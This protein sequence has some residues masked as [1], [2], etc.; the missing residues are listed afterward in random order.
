MDTRVKVAHCESTGRKW[1]REPKLT[2][3]GPRG[4]SADSA[5]LSP[6]P[7]SS[8]YPKAATSPPTKTHLKIDPMIPRKGQDGAQRLG[9]YV[10]CQNKFSWLLAASHAS[11]RV[12]ND[13]SL[14]SGVEVEPEFQTRVLKCF[15]ERS[16]GNGNAFAFN[17]NACRSSF[18]S[19]L[20]DP[21][22]FFQGCGANGGYMGFVCN[23][24]TN[25]SPCP[26]V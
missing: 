4:L 6:H 16:T 7:T 19:A 1:V 18:L 22:F 24:L 17:Q 14:L 5:W 10:S 25:V 2:P 26:N 9:R 8:L 20:S 21:F 3:Q 11:S 15:V 13:S 23:S 12:K